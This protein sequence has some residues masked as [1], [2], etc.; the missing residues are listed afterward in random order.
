LGVIGSGFNNWGADGPD[1]SFTPLSNNIWV[2]EIVP[3]IDGE[4]KFRYNEDWNHPLGDFGDSSADGT[5]DAG[6]TNIAVTTG[7]YRIVLDLAS[8]TYQINKVN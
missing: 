7:N 5:L 6:G 3:L 8:S 2:A 1:F 4:I